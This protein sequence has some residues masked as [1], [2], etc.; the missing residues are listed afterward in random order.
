MWSFG[1]INGYEYQVKAYD[2]GSDEFGIKGGRISKLFVMKDGQIVAHFNDVKK[3]SDEQ[4][5][6]YMLG[7]RK[8][9]PEEME[10]L[11]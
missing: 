1:K 8:M 2:E 3:V 6:E 4:L 5:G 7:I 10:G 11:S 9:S